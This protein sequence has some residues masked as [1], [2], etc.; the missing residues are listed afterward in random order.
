M[1]PSTISTGELAARLGAPDVR[2]VDTR[3]SLQGDDLG[4]RA[5]EAGHIPGAVYLHWY[6]DLSD[7]DDPVPGQLAPPARFR[8]TMER[9]GIGDG[10]LVVAYDDG[11]IFMA[12][13]L[14]WC[15]RTYG[16]DAVRILDGGWPAWEREGRAT[17]SGR[18]PAPPPATFT[19]RPGPPIRATKDDVRDALDSGAVLLDCRMDE[20]W[21]AVGLHI[22]GARRL[23]APSLVDADG[24]L[25]DESEIARRAAAAGADPEADV[26]LYCG[27][28]ISA[29]LAYTA[30][31]RAGYRRLRVYDGSWNE[32]G[33][34]PALPKEPHGSGTG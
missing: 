27:G 19:P 14:L 2:V 25:E 11:V 10:T 4:E 24:Y 31:E 26:V 9:A 5:Y 20:T 28:G 8:E 29:S 12:A 23:P 18:A 6:R 15:L 1:A 16:H 17:E 22:P 13:R 3:F 34:D 7:P 21:N 30:L 32:W 33:T